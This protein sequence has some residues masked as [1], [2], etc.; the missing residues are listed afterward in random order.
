MQSAEH[1]L[2]NY[3]GNRNLV[4][5]TDASLNYWS[6]VLALEMEG[7]NGQHLDKLRVVPMYFYSGK[8][9]G[10]MFHWNV[11]D[12]EI[13]PVMKTL[14]RFKYLTEVYPAKLKLLTDSLNLVYLFKPPGTVKMTSMSRPFR[15]VLLLQGFK[16]EVW[17]VSGTQNRLA[18][19]LTRWGYYGRALEDNEK[20]LTALEYIGSK[21]DK[22]GDLHVGNT[23][24]KKG[25]ALQRLFLAN[26]VE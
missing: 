6:A 8:F 20:P 16:L 24:L 12:K 5:V 26:V 4:L 11:P 7:D 9:T 15:C 21:I 10:S 1:I 2:S 25:A 17:H 13:Y 14:I 22:E 18:D 23:I 19:T 3:N